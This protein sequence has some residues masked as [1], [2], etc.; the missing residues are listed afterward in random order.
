MLGNEAFRWAASAVL[1]AA[2]LAAFLAAVWP[3]PSYPPAFRI[4]RGLNALMLTSLALMLHPSWTVPVLPQILIFLLAAWWFVLRA[5]SRR[6]T[7]QPA[8]LPAG[9]RRARDTGRGTG[10]GTLLYHALTMAAMAYMLLAGATS[11]ASPV[12]ARSSAAAVV[13]P[14]H[15]AAAPTA[16]LLPELATAGAVVLPSLLAAFFGF[17]AI[18]WSVRLIRQLLSRAPGGSRSAFQELAGAAL[19]ALMFV[20]L[21]AS[22]LPA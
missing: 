9:R 7:S 17:A 20:S 11:G 18:L 21:A 4:D 22:R 6:P 5:S 19:M 10:R 13:A 14:H 3:S 2:A 16:V 15:F 8:S 12:P 1:L